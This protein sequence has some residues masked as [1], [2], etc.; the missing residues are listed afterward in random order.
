MAI[1]WATDLL[2]C[3]LNKLFK[4][5]VCSLATVL[6]TFPTIGQFFPNHLVTVH[7]TK[8][9]NKAENLTYF[10]ANIGSDHGFNE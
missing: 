9:V 6:A 10:S 4:K 1:P 7:L 2:H 3:H 8:K 5:R